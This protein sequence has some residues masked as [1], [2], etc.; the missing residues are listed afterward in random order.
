MAIKRFVLR[1]FLV[2][3]FLF[4]LKAAALAQIPTAP[5]FIY[6]KE[7]PPG[8][9]LIKVPYR[10]QGHLE[11]ILMNSE[12]AIGYFEDD[13]IPQ[14]FFIGIVTKEQKEE[15][16]LLEYTFEI[17]DTQPITEQ[18]FTA[19]S[20]EPKRY[21]VFQ[22]QFTFWPISDYDILIKGDAEHIHPLLDAQ[23]FHPRP[24]AGHITLRPSAIASEQPSQPSLPGTSLHNKLFLRLSL[25]I[26]ILASGL[27]GML[28]LQ[29]DENSPRLPPLKGMRTLSLV[30]ALTIS[31]LVVFFV[32]LML[33]A[34]I[35][36]IPI[37][38]DDR[39]L[40]VEEL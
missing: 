38:G 31:A 27:I 36:Q 1:L 7:L 6:S 23:G 2:L 32:R 29:P 16:E 37:G 28:M 40:R 14:P 35:L 4:A 30:I 34:S 9:L 21:S 24:I 18:Y 25:I 11:Q 22:G 10:V 19:F 5:P 17:L 33:P 12:V 3:I 13:T 15:L 26:V 8:S 39:Y 20:Y